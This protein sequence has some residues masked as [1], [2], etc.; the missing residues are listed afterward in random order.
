MSRRGSTFFCVPFNFDAE[1]SKDSFKYQFVAIDVTKYNPQHI[2]QYLNTD[3]QR[4]VTQKEAISDLGAHL[5]DDLSHLYSS[6][7]DQSRPLNIDVD[8]EHW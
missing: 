7:C 2:P 4:E 5:F 8:E 6:H 3:R 1:G